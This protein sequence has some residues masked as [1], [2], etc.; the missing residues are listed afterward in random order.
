VCGNF[1]ERSTDKGRCLDFTG[2][3]SDE[4]E[5]RG[6]KRGDYIR[7]RSRI[8]GRGGGTVS[9]IEG[10]TAGGENRNLRF[11]NWVSGSRGSPLDFD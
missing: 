5:G 11:K 2:G 10:F 4:N 9:G 3:G 7:H 6:V 1:D 8:H